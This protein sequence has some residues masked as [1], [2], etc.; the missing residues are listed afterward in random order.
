MPLNEYEIMNQCNVQMNFKANESSD[1][2]GM[3]LYL[4]HLNFSRSNDSSYG[5]KDDN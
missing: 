3:K 2:D 1:D 4:L 5:T